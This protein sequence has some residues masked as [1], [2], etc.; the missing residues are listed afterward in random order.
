MSTVSEGSTPGW[1][2]H[3]LARASE[4]ASRSGY[5]DSDDMP[6]TGSLIGCLLRGLAA[7]DS[8]E[9]II[10][11]VSTSLSL[12]KTPRW[13]SEFA[14]LNEVRSRLRAQVAAPSAGTVATIFG[15]TITLVHVRVPSRR[16][17]Q[18]HLGP[19]RQAKVSMCVD[20]QGSTASARFTLGRFVRPLTA[21]DQAMY[22]GWVTAVMC[23][24]ARH[25]SSPSSDG[26]STALIRLLRPTTPYSPE[27]ILKA[28]TA[29]TW[30]TDPAYLLAQDD[31]FLTNADMDL[32]FP[33]LRSER[34]FRSDLQNIASFSGCYLVLTDVHGLFSRWH[35][36][37]WP[38][39]SSPLAERLSP[40]YDEYLSGRLS[41]SSFLRSAYRHRLAVARDLSMTLLAIADAPGLERASF[42]RGDGVA[43]IARSRAELQTVLGAD[44]TFRKRCL[45]FS[46][47]A[48][49]ISADEPAEDVLSRAEFA[50]AV[51][52]LCTA[53][54]ERS[55]YVHDDELSRIC[56]SALRE[57]LARPPSKGRATR[58]KTA[59]L[60]ERHYDM[61]AALV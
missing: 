22:A 18:E 9:I 44:A 3:A 48:A 16:S 61:L 55:I 17:R 53:C 40:I 36:D 12:R 42:T 54:P 57:R 23:S 4:Y 30:R 2:S 21:A 34:S 13:Q 58:D 6:D 20:V 35:G 59:R 49:R 5:F 47:G 50:L 26:P 7:H 38:T 10:E 37:V 28:F 25:L 14:T 29:P 31:T 33:W 15:K 43:A 52:K 1:L 24:R 27:Q 19:A 46:V 51:T 8:P 32:H 45:P 56:A 41:L 39:G 60:I 11:L